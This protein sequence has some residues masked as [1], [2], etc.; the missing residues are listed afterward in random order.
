M[1][2]SPDL[3]PGLTVKRHDPAQVPP[4]DGALREKD[5]QSPIHN[6]GNLEARTNGRGRHEK[7]RRVGPSPSIL[8]VF[9]YL[10]P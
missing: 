1:L 5:Q 7:G 6:G 2:D 4:S 10:K 3:S 9:G 8:P